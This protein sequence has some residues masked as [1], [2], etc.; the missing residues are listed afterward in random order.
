[1]TDLI[2]IE[3]ISTKILILRGKRVMLDKDL[4]K[5]Y[6][7]PTKVL[8]QSVKRNIRRFPID[9]MFQL[10]KLEKLELVTICDRF[11]LLKHSTVE[12]YVFTEQGVAMLSSVL[13]SERAI[14]VN[15]QIMRAFTQ[16]RR[17]LLTNVDL[18]RKIEEMERKYDKQFLIVFKVIKEL[19]EPQPIPNKPPIGFR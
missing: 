18:K 4:A 11:R 14:L 12:P 13:N 15:I 1:M 5:L 10:T 6:A 19:L 2:P 17:M 7:V 16:L 8:N 3:L 9:F